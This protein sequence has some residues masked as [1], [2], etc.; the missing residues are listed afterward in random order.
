VIGTTW[1]VDDVASVTDGDTLRVYRSRIDQLGDDWYH[2]TDVNPDGT[3]RSVPI[4]L[5]WVNTPERGKPGWA[6][7]KADLMDWIGIGS[8]LSAPALRVVC[9]ESAGWD[10]VLGDLIDA[11]GNSASQ[12]LMIERGWPPYAGS[13]A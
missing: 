10:R 2:V 11:D 7:A 9:Y 8:T 1:Q 6:D 12:W 5:V 3:P 13:K 4:R